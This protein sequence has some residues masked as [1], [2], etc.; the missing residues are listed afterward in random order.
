MGSYV[1]G[2]VKRIRVWQHYEINLTIRVY[3]NNQGL[4]FYIVIDEKELDEVHKS[5]SKMWHMKLE[6]DEG[7]E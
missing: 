5:Q 6:V 1:M 4:L 7:G 3:T 2:L